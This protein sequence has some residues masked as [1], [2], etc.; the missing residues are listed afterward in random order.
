MIE[1]NDIKPIVKI[2]DL[3]IYIY[4]TLF[5]VAFLLLVVIIFYLYKFFKKKPK[6]IEQKYYEKLQHINFEN[7]KQS[8]Y[9][10]S[11]YGKLLVKEERQIR[12]F[13]EL[14]EE[15]EVYKYKKEITI[16]ISEKIKTKFHIFM[17]SLD[18]K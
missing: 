12:L 9:L 17:E 1:I 14:N 16:Q 11:K 2:P 18:V 3:S 6:T 8:A 15:L 7:S 10:I 5:I 4:Y 13:E